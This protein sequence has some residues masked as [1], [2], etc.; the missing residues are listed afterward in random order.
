MKISKI[1]IIVWIFD[2]SHLLQFFIIL[3]L[4]GA[5][6]VAS[7]EQ[8]STV[9]VAYCVAA[10]LDIYDSNFMAVIAHDIAPYLPDKEISYFGA[11]L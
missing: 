6:Q 9:S 8:K 1:D 7:R 2:V 3:K 10:P 5:Q 11:G 4:P